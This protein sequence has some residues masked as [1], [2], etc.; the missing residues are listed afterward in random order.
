MIQNREKALNTIRHYIP[1]S[2]LFTPDIKIDLDLFIKDQMLFQRIAESLASGEQFENTT[3]LSEIKGMFKQDPTPYVSFFYEACSAALKGKAHSNNFKSALEGR[4]YTL[5][6]ALIAQHTPLSIR[7][8][9]EQNGIAPQDLEKIKEE[10]ASFIRDAIWIHMNDKNAP[11]KEDLVST[12]EQLIPFV[13]KV[14]KVYLR[15]LKRVCP[16]NPLTFRNPSGYNHHGLLAAT[17]MEACLYVLGFKTQTMAR[18]DLEPKVTLATAH[19]VIQVTAPDHSKY[20]LDPCYTQFHQDI[21]LDDEALPPVLVLEESE[22]DPYI[23]KNLMDQWRKS[24]AL[25]EQEDQSVIEKLIEK[26][27]IISHIVQNLSLPKELIPSNLESWVKNSLKRVWDLKTYH[28]L[29][30]NRGFEEIFLDN[31]VAPQTHA[32]IKAMGIAA[33]THHSSIAEVEKQLDQ[34]LLDPNLKGQNCDQAL[35]LILY[36]PTANRAKYASLLDTDPRITALEL[37]LN[38]YFRSL[39]KEVN[40]KGEDKR[41]IYGCS[42]A[43]CITVMLATDAQDFLF[44]DTT[45]TSL[46]E[47]EQ[48]LTLLTDSKISELDLNSA[49]TQSDDYLFRRKSYGG[50][51]SNLSNGVQK[52]KDLALKL[53]HDLRAAGVDL[54][55]VVLSK[56]K[57]GVRID[58]PWQYHGAASAR[59]R[60]LTF[61]TA[62]VT[63]PDIYPSLL[64][65]KIEEGFDIFYLK[66]A[67]L[68]PQH[69]PQFLPHLAKSIRKGGWLMTADKTFL[70]ETCSPDETLRE[71]GLEF[72]HHRMAKLKIMEALTLPP[73]DP[74]C[75]VPQLKIPPSQRMCR[76]TGSDLSYWSHLTLR[77]KI[78]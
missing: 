45:P 29:F 37:I 46:Y 53:L 49:L 72:E 4:I 73:F 78:N 47:F 13:Q 43:D 15:E 14:T 48:A 75:A 8:S 25:V 5:K 63:R 69:Y 50:S 64:K 19:S 38:T 1:L 40:P 35:S 74:L 54:S 71:N 67:Y 52:M 55:Q 68:A 24:H 32:Y 9:Q 2:T 31:R 21:C 10:G 22:I 20:L 30:F 65:T 56:D 26:E 27:Q 60:T 59:K 70:M 18:C 17:V 77:K 61:L 7:K 6:N 28:T 12:S 41:V 36:L 57:E 62:D 11:F 39:K 76:M 51:T 33:L 3:L 44:V 16:D 23:E 66:A 58:F 34:L 42:G